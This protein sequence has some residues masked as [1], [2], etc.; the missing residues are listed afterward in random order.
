[1]LARQEAPL[2]RL[3][4]DTLQERPGDLAIEQPLAVFREDRGVPEMS[5]R[6]L[7]TV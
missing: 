1:M 3:L 5:C 4:N 2:T 7:R 6:S